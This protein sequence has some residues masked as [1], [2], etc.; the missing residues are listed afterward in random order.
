VE[1][2]EDSKEEEE[3]FQEEAVAFPAEEEAF[4]KLADLTRG[5]EILHLPS[6]LVL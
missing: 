6:K 1:E 5:L 3:A 2:L 4:K